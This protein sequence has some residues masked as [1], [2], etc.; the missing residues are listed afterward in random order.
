MKVSDYILRISAFIMIVVIL[1][2]AG[3]CKSNDNLVNTTDDLQIVKRD[4]AYPGCYPVIS[5]SQMF[6]W[7]STGNIITAPLLDDPF[8][9]QDAQFTHTSAVY[10]KSSDGLTVK[11]QVTG[12]TWQK[13][14]DLGI[15]YW[16]EA[17][18]VILSLNKQNYGGYSDWRLPTIK[19]LY[20]LWNGSKG[21]PYIDTEYF[22][23]NYS[24]EEDLSH[25][26]FWSSDKYTGVMGNISGNT[27]GAELAFGVNFGTGHIKAYSIS[28]GPKHSVRLVTG[29]LAYGENLFQDNGNGTVSDLATGLMWQQS[30]NSAGINWE[31]ALAYAQTKNKANY[32]G[33][34]D[35]RLPN[36]KELQSLV[37]YTRS[38]GAT[39]A[40]KVGPAINAPFSC[41]AITNDGG[42]ADYPYYWTST[43][44]ISKANGI[45]ANA[46]Y[47]AFGRAEDGN[48]E[49][50]HGAGAVRFDSKIKGNSAGEERVL[51]YVRLVR[52]IK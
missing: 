45:Y 48:G 41:T 23:I 13:S 26:I 11:D 43:S 42:K 1:T 18:S 32:L 44:A 15:Y 6:C 40:A 30:D 47:V 38:P 19:E 33:Y 8:Y 36:S 46:W 25:A 22:T 39:N 16:A 20:S 12:L 29:N 24:S 27:P 37:D 3:G 50:L 34:N 31:D 5:T 2:T 7:D 14:Y 35:W 10:T 51:N 52:T 4:P 49:D 28:V 9:G 21:W 17:Q